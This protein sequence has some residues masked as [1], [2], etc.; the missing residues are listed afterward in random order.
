MK[1]K[2]ILKQKEKNTEPFLIRFLNTFSFKKYRQKRPQL[3]D[4]LP[5]AYFVGDFAD[6]IVLLKTGALMRCYSFICPDLGSASS[7]SIEQVSF[8]FNESLKRLES[9]WMIQFE[10]QRGLTG[11]YPGSKWA[12]NNI[13]GYIIDSRRKELYRGQKVHFAN[14]FYLTFTYQMENEIYKKAKN[15][16]YKEDLDESGSYYDL[17]R[18]MSEIA[19]FTKT[20]D[21]IIA[22]L[23]NKIYLEKMDADQ[24][25]TYMHASVSSRWHQ[26]NIPHYPCLCDHYITDV[27][28]NT[29]VPLQVGDTYVGIISVHDFPQ[30]TYP[31]IFD[32]LNYAQIE[33]RWSIRWIAESREEADK[34]IKKLQ[35]RFYGSRKSWATALSESVMSYESGKEDPS[36]SEF[37][38]DT[39]EAKIRLSNGEVGYGYYTC[40]CQVWDTD[41]K[42][43]HQKIS[44]II[45]LINSMGFTAKEETF[46]AFEAWCSMQP[47]NAYAN[48]RQYY[49]STGNASHLVPLSSIWEGL[50]V[51]KWTDEC[52]DVPAPLLVC[53]SDATTAFFLNL[54][55]GDLGH[56]FIFGISGGGKSTH[57]CLLES[58]FTK[59]RGANVVILDKDRTA[60]CITMAHGGVYAEPGTEKV[61]FQPLRDLETESDLS[62]AAEFIKLLL[63]EQGTPIDAGRSEAIVSA[64]KQLKAEKPPEKRTLTS[65]QQYCN[66]TDPLT[67]TNTIRES[68]QPY[69]IG[70]EY[71]A[72][73]DA[74]DTTLALS[75]WVMIEMGTL[76]KMGEK[77]VTPALMFLFRFIEK[78]YT[79]PQGYPTGDPTILVL[80]EAWVFLDNEFFAKTIEEWL[81]TLRKK[82]V[83]CV[84]ATQ[85]VA[86]VA[87]SSLATTIIS[88]CLTKIYGADPQASSTAIAQYY[89]T[90]E[91]T[92]DEIK[93]IA[94]MTM[95]RD[96]FYKSPLGARKYS[97]DLDQLQ[98]ALLTPDHALLDR[99]EKKYG[100]N[101]MKPLAIEILREK[102]IHGWEKYFKNPDSL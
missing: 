64:L 88:Q 83:F 98:L 36:A 60:R 34:R 49:I 55:I 82:R 61:A 41:V 80:D 51:N 6:G 52:F 23:R 32:S 96:Y 30:E 67:N 101:S 53:S 35:S 50:K 95:K 75:K 45:S 81:V 68:I 76:M 79:T 97:L 86:K 70:G 69:T 20:T 24:C 93:T 90:F 17:E 48:I 38:R 71:G 5:W 54:N 42:I 25:A 4:Y 100:R 15:I 99:L 22:P 11:D 59:Y 66:Y 78:M 13:A 85:E 87:K 73:F 18:C 43:L 7:D 1:Q 33:Y 31:A 94:S 46:N 58:Q 37:E 63:I 16:F 44:Y 29:N 3:T 91:L 84:F 9:R 28:V 72:V 10:A 26:V 8:Y 56:S 21:A 89:R 47:G 19:E 40:T 102:N 65:F 92:D 74:S 77:C 62:W 57:L 12:K 2:K 39:K 14:Q 27:D